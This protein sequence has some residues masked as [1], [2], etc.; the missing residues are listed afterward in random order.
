MKDKLI[1]SYRMLKTYNGTLFVYAFSYALII[2]IA[3]FLIIAVLIASNFVLDMQTMIEFLGYYIPTD[4]IVPFINYVV[5]IAPSDFILLISLA[6]VS[7]WVASRSVYSFLLESSRI[8]K[9]EIPSLILRVV[10]VLYFAFIIVGAFVVF[11][12]VSYLPPYNYITIPLLLWFMMIVFYR[13]ISFRFSQF[14]DVY[15]GA[16]IATAGLIGLGRLFFTY[17]NDYSNYQSIYGPLA[18]LMIMLISVYFIS[19]IIYFG[20]CINVVLF[21]DSDR[22][23][24]LEN[25]L[26]FKISQFNLKNFINKFRS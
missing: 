20:F 6:S 7:F 13:L 25:K 19:Y 11:V 14:S 1:E 26:I 8:D 16:G 10:S 21:D 3:P 12:L 18:S 2:G 4:L 5:E 24:N 9:F 17:V 22:D 15:M 23:L